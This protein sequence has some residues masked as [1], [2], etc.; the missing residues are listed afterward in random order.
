MSGLSSTDAIPHG[1]GMKR[2]NPAQPVTTLQLLDTQQVGE[3]LQVGKTKVY[4][5]IKSGELPS[6]LIGKSR[7]VP[8]AALEAFIAEK[9]SAA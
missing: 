7:R 5:L 2:T 9:L 4:E 6:V 3:R 8:V 1:V